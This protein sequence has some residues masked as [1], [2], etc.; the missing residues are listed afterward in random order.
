MQIIC[1]QETLI[2]NMYN[3]STLYRVKCFR[4]LKDVFRCIY[5]AVPSHLILILKLVEIKIGIH[6]IKHRN[7][8]RMFTYGFASC[9]KKSFS[10]CCLA[11]FL[12]DVLTQFW[13]FI[14]NYKL[15]CVSH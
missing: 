3:I 6:E 8:G 9:S 12:L 14:D 2:T 13:F 15:M 11:I 4:L 5:S 7:P 1:Q 10:A